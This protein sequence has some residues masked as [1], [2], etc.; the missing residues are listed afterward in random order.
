MIEKNITDLSQ[1][2]TVQGEALTVLQL[3]PGSESPETSVALI[4][5]HGRN[6]KVRNLESNTKYSVIAG[7][8]CFVLWNGEIPEIRRVKAGD[9]VCIPRGMFYQDVGHMLMVSINSPAFDSNKVE[10]AGVLVR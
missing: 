4:F 6:E 1:F 7:T 2:Q 3:L 8:G 9:T 10:V 5:L